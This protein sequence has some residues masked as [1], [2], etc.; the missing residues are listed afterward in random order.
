MC[1]CD[2]AGQPDGRMSLTVKPKKWLKKSVVVVWGLVL[3]TL[4]MCIQSKEST[5]FQPLCQT[6]MACKK[7]KLCSCK[8]ANESGRQWCYCEKCNKSVCW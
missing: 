3:Q 7:P 8:S 4:S 6:D 5:I 2:Y 1:V